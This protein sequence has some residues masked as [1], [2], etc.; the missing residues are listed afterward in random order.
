[1]GR[2]DPQPEDSPARQIAIDLAGDVALQDTDDLVCGP[3]L[4]HPALEVGPGP[5]VVRDAHHDDAP[6]RA[7][8]LAVAALVTPDL[9][10]LL[11]DPVGM[12]DTP[13]RW[14]Q[15]ASDGGARGCRRR[16]SP[17]S[18]PRSS[19]QLLLVTDHAA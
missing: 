12:G 14:A 8:G 3:A 2:A 15:A 19:G 11:A 18:F 1:M 6:P 9:A 17:V 16:P 10:A 7:V 4:L 5:L 13:H